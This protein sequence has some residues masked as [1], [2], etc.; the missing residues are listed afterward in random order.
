M[1]M[2]FT[3]QTEDYKSFRAKIPLKRISV[4]ETKV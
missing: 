3:S 4:E 1:R 2:S